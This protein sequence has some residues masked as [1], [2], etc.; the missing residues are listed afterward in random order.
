MLRNLFQMA[1]KLI[2]YTQ[3]SLY[4]I[5]DIMAPLPNVY[6]N[7]GY[8]NLSWQTFPLWSKFCQ[9]PEGCKTYPEGCKTYPECCKTYPECCKTYPEC[10]KTYPECCKTYPEGC[11]TYPDSTHSK[12]CYQMQMEKFASNSISLSNTEAISPYDGQVKS[13][14]QIHSYEE[15]VDRMLYEKGKKTTFYIADKFPSLW[16]ELNGDEDDN[17]LIEFHP[18]LKTTKSDYKEKYWNAK[19]CW[20]KWVYIGVDEDFIEI[21]DIADFEYRNY[22]L[23]LCSDDKQVFDKFV[24]ELEVETFEKGQYTF[25]TEMLDKI[26]NNKS[27]KYT[28]C[29]ARQVIDFIDITDSSFNYDIYFKIATNSI[30]L[31]KSLVAHVIEHLQGINEFEIFSNQIKTAPL[32]KII[33]LDGPQDYTNWEWRVCGPK[34][35]TEIFISKLTDLS[36]KIKLVKPKKQLAIK[37]YEKQFSEKKLVEC[38]EETAYMFMMY[39]LLSKEFCMFLEKIQKSEYQSWE[40]PSGKHLQVTNGYYTFNWK[41]KKI[42]YTNDIYDNMTNTI[43]CLQDN[44]Y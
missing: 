17:E 18:K 41:G 39:N 23:M 37:E 38:K 32:W 24:N 27:D 22:H 43:K 13:W 6:H 36:R 35:K 30:P 25:S 10:C 2:P 16:K 7:D 44:K 40:W 8:T 15:I 42:C 1:E 14:G 31:L 12:S 20:Y 11:K 29:N 28:Y 26:V 33:Y 19:L 4:Q 21:D 9:C 5:L 34:E 3:L